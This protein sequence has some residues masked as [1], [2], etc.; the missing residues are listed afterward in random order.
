M[1]E[2][3][4]YRTLKSHSLGKL[5]SDFS[6]VLVELSATYSTFLSSMRV[7]WLNFFLAFADLKKKEVVKTLI[8]LSFSR[9]R[10]E[11]VVRSVIDLTLAAYIFLLL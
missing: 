4:R 6:L 10:K 8:S 11:Q 3:K 1:T 2:I 7:R 5:Q 9:T